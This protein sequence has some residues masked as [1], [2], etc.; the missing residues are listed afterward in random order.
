MLKI[1]AVHPYRSI[2]VLLEEGHLIRSRSDRDSP[3]VAKIDA[4]QKSGVLLAKLSLCSGSASRKR[5]ASPNFIESPRVT[6]VA[7]D[8]IFGANAEPAG[9]PDIN[10]VVLSQR[11]LCHNGW[12]GFQKHNRHDKRKN[13]GW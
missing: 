4:V 6:L 11:L 12:R 10:G 3:V 1:R 9:H 13:L 5:V 7:S 2:D 8:K